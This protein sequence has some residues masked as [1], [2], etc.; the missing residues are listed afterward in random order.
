MSKK[1]KKGKEDDL[2]SSGTKTNRKNQ[3]SLNSHSVSLIIY[4]ILK[5][6]NSNSEKI[7]KVKVTAAAK[8]FIFTKLPFLVVV[9]VVGHY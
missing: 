8:H 6:Q 9:V 3:K 7:V 5:H 4:E 2:L 1:K